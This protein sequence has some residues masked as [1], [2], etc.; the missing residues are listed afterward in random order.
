MQVDIRIHLNE[1]TARVRECKVRVYAV[2]LV[3]SVS[4]FGAAQPSQPSH[5]SPAQPSPAQPSSQL[6]SN[7]DLARQARHHA[8]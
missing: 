4:G 3:K 2:S 5:P 8:A 7:S 6:S 1:M